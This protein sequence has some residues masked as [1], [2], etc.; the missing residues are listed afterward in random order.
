MKAASLL[1]VST[2][3]ACAHADY[4][5]FPVKSINL[6]SAATPLFYHNL[7]SSVLAAAPDETITNVPSVS[8]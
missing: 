6:A 8:F 2:L 1:L 4:D 7:G 5:N 3:C